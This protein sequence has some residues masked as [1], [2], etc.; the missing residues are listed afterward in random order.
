MWTLYCLYICIPDGRFG[1]SQLNTNVLGG[2]PVGGGGDVDDGRRLHHH[3]EAVMLEAGVAVVEHHPHCADQP[4]P[5]VVVTVGA[6]AGEMH[7][8][9]QPQRNLAG[10]PGVKIIDPFQFGSK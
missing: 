9:A 8:F 4:L 6:G 10:N 7:K 1:Q 5:D 2:L 3:A